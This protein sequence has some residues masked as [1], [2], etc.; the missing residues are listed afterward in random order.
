V[1][2]AII[3]DG[4]I[5]RVTETS[6]SIDDQ[7]KDEEGEIEEIYVLLFLL[8]PPNKLAGPRPSLL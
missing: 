2:D 8:T 3:V 5:Q 7:I 4:H 6:I 1:D